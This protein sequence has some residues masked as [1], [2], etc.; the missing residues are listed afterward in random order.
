MGLDT[1]KEARAV[2]QR[3][4]LNKDFESLRSDLMLYARTFY[5]S[6]ITDFSESAMGGVLLDMPA[7]VGDVFSF[8]GDHQ[9]GELF[10]ESAVEKQN[11]EN[12][13]RAAGVEITGNSPAV[14]P[15]SFFIEVPAIKQG[16]TF[17][18]RPDS[19][20]VIEEGSVCQA[21][22]GTRFELLEDLDYAELDSSDVFKADIVIGATNSDGSPATLL[23]SRTGDSVSGFTRTETF[24]ISN[25]FLAFR[26]IALGAEDITEIISVR[27]SDGNTYYEVKALTQ[28]TVFKAM[29]NL[30]EDSELVPMNLEVLP[31]PYRF[32]KEMGLD[33]RL[34]TLTFG[35]GTAT[36]LDNDIIPDPSEFAVPLF[37]KK[38]FSRF[39]I[40]PGKLLDTRTLGVAPQNTTLIV[41]YRFGGGLSHNVPSTTIET[42][43]QLL[44]KFP[45][46]PSSAIAASVR[47][48]TSVVNMID[49][50]GGENA[51]TINELKTRVPSARNS[52]SRI[53]NKEDLL[54]R[55]YTMPSNF[56]RVFRAGIR[57]N[58][59]NPLAT[60]LYV[61]SRDQ[62]KKLVISPDTLKQNVATYLNQFRLI[63]DAIDILDTRV[64]NIKIE[65]Q[66]STESAT[67]KSTLVRN[68]IGRLQKFFRIDNF[69]IDQPIRRSEVEN[70][71]FNNPGVMSVI[72]L[73]IRNVVG[74]INGKDYSDNTFDVAANTRN[75]LIIGPPGS[76]FEIR[77]PNYD[78]IG[79]A[80]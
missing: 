74:T 50:R 53:V 30:N 19:L 10:V 66:I 29:T 2:R 17:V 44:M 14:V 28:D 23:M 58:P 60:Q 35:G 36:S 46:N 77:F 24:V 22:N 13:V 62:K 51:P 33:T 57:D 47:G 7:Y 8:Y 64:V 76:I 39:T 71:I 55:I 79:S 75:G 26:R 31:A 16:T 12:H 34:T 20:P 1:K 18:P 65:F 25:S 5:R 41:E 15:I 37:G 48:S 32:L 59:N 72:D 6:R 67:N 70:L 63:S 80:L 68:I 38:T 9:F 21:N 11:I 3:R 42:P 54:A 73:K 78:I 61:I 56:G 40:D 45:E 49:A 52:Q 43:T 27:D 4:Y 69:Q